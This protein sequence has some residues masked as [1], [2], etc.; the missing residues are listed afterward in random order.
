MAELGFDVV[1]LDVDERKVASLN[2]GFVPFFE[3]DLEELLRK[4]LDAG[5]VRFATPLSWS[6][7][8]SSSARAGPSRTPCARTGWCSGSS[9]RGASRFSARSTHRSSTTGFL[10]S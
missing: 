8:R 2:D 10:S 9:R 6:G 7:T 1:G 4:N 5:R 3:P